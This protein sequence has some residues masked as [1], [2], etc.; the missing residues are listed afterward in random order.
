M[1]VSA[2]TGDPSSLHSQSRMKEYSTAILVIFLHTYELNPFKTLGFY[3]RF[4]TWAYCGFL[5]EN[6]RLCSFLINF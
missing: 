2:K 1:D 6:T 5:T 3:G 4:K